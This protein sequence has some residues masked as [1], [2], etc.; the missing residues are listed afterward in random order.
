MPL[1]TG[2][3]PYAFAFNSTTDVCYIADDRTNGAGGIQKWVKTV[4]LWSLSYTLSAGTNLGARGLIVDF[5]GIS[6]VLFATTATTTNFTSNQ[7]IKIDSGNK[8]NR[9]QGNF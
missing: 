8:P 7:L 6:P 9:G 1:P 3:S 5:S 2:S 4:G